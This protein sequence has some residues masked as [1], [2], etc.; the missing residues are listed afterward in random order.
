MNKTN[1]D[2]MYPGGYSSWTYLPYKGQSNVAVF[3]SG[4]TGYVYNRDTGHWEPYYPGLQEGGE[5]LEGGMVVVGEGSRPELI[6]LP[7]GATVTPLQHGEE[8]M[9]NKI[10]SRILAAIS[11]NRGGGDVHF[12][13]L[14]IVDR[15]GLL[16]LNQELRNLDPL[17]NS[18]RGLTT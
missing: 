2:R 12:H 13:G 7:K 11:G 16:R 15:A 9:I 6:N 1:I 18:R 3:Y 5:I 4:N 10:V 8:D 14:F 17:E